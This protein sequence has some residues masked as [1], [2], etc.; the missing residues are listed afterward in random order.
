MVGRRV[1]RSLTPAVAALAI[2]L[3][4]A[5]AA[6]GEA[7]LAA[8]ATEG[9]A[10]SSTTTYTIDPVAGVVRVSAV[11]E[12][13]NTIPDRIEGNV[14]RRAYFD[15]ITL[16]VPA[17]ALNPV[18]T[19]TGQTLTVTPQFVEGTTDFY[20]ID[21]EFARRLFF[22]QTAT[23]ELTYDLTGLPPRSEN[24]WRVNPAYASFSAFGVGDPGMV[25]IQVIAPPDFTVELFGETAD[26]T[27]SSD[28]VNTV[29]TAT[30]IAA[31]DEFEVYIS[32][33]NP[34]ALDSQPVDVG[35][36]RFDL[37]AWPDDD[38]WEVFVA[39]RLRR[40]VPA[41][42][43]LTGRPWPI[44]DVLTVRQTVT[45]YLYGYAGWFDPLQNQIE[46]G[47]DLDAEVVL[48][49]LSHAWFNRG[50]FAERWVNE[51][52]AQVFAA[53]A[54]QQL[55]GV[56]STPQPVDRAS[57]V[58]FPLIEW[59]VPVGEDADDAEAYG[60][61]TAWFVVDSLADEIGMDAM[62]AVLLAVD[63]GQIAYVGEG[64]PEGTARR[65]TGWQRLLDLLQERGGSEQAVALFEQYVLTDSSSTLFDERALA[66][67]AYDDLCA[68]SGT[69]SPPLPIRAAMDGW[70]FGEATA[71]IADAADVVARHE[72]LAEASAA[73]GVDVPASFEADYEAVDES[74]AGVRADID[75]QRAA[76]D[77]VATA[78]ELEAGDDGFFDGIGLIG[79]DLDARLDEARAAL[80]AG[81]PVTA[82]AIAADVSSTLAE[83]ER[84]GQRRVTTAAAVTAAAL[85]VV[86]VAA[87]LTARRRRAAGSAEPG[88]DAT[89]T[90]PDVGD[91]GDAADPADPPDVV[92]GRSG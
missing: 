88:G 47:E 21:V 77:R 69:W 3:T 73:L 30:N 51:G 20:I 84:V 62:R 80:S 87:V 67:A 42:V 45:P 28:G 48:H 46:V 19:S 17:G 2:G 66:R 12:V 25:T 92:E 54:E 76:V 40:G 22:D 81:D 90:S 32:A 50:W 75:E 44:D 49:E 58:A 36:A 43:E 4:V 26:I 24:P 18:A 78:I 56:E 31:P 55:D 86:I 53:S 29:L 65:E 83:A 7:R 5:A 70:E 11:I 59:D 39:D 79:S 91:A 68:S 10:T 61:N 23:I 72:A 27:R 52:M 34:G 15:G 74:F 1:A 38:E 33:S 85:A 9:L 41:L 64:P 13:R 57:R 35:D 63:E 14:V 82:T 60:Y 16:P 6:P 89:V 71:L 8:Q 37:R